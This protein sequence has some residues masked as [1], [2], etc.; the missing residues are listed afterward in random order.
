MLAYF[1]A[2][3]P[4]RNGMTMKTNPEFTA[5]NKAHFAMVLALMFGIPL[6]VLFKIILATV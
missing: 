5:F 6:Y 2:I 3:L 4:N 1:V